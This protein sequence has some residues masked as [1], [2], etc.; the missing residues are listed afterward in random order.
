MKR[1]L[2]VIIALIIA[3]ASLSSALAVTNPATDA[4]SVIQAEDFSEASCSSVLGLGT[5]HYLENCLDVGGGQNVFDWQRNTYFKYEN[6][7]FG[8]TGAIGFQARV[9]DFSDDADLKIILDRIDGPVVGTL[10]IFST[11]KQQDWE[12]QACPITRT[13]G[14]HTVYLKFENNYAKASLNYF[15]FL[16]TQPEAQIIP[17]YEYTP[18]PTDWTGRDTKPDTWA[19][20][21]LLGNEIAG[22]YESGAP[23]ENK[24]VGIFYHLFL[25]R[26]QGAVYDNS[27]LL[28]ENYFDPAYGPV[29][30]DHF[31][32]K[33][34][35]DYY[36]NTDVYVIKKHAQLLYNAGVDVIIFDT[37]NAGFPFTP[38]WSVIVDTLYQMR[39]D[40]IQTPQIAF[41][42]GDTAEN[43]EK[44]IPYL[45]EHIYSVEK[46]KELW[47][48]WEG[49]PLILA[50]SSTL[51]TVYQNEF[52]FR[53][54]WA[55][56]SG[57]NQWPWLDN[58]PQGYGWSV[59]S[60]T[61]EATSVC[62]AQHATTFKGKS[63]SD[64]VQPSNPTEAET[65][66]M[67]NFC[68]QWERALELDPQFIFVTAWNEWVA[69]N[70]Y[71]S[72]G[73]EFLGRKLS[74][75]E[76]Y[77]IDEYSP[78]FSRDIEPTDGFLADE[79][80][81][82]LV[83]YIR[84]FKG[85]RSVEAASGTKTI[86]INNDFSQWGDVSPEYLDAVDDVTHRNELAYAGYT[87]LINTSGRNDFDSL[88]VAYDE[89]NLYFYA[90]TVA[91]IS[92]PAESNWMTLLI[93]SDN[94][95]STGWNGYDFIFNRVLVDANT[96]KLQRNV[97]NQWEWEDVNNID[98]VVS[99]NQ[100]HFAIPRSVLGLENDELKF[101][102][103]WS[104][105]AS[106]SGDV[107]D[108]Y[109]I[110]DTAPD[111]RFCYQFS[112]IQTNPVHARPNKSYT[113]TV[114]ESYEKY[115]AEYGVRS[116]GLAFES[117]HS[118]FSGIGYSAGFETIGDSL[119]LKIDSD[120]AGVYAAK[121][122]Y[123]NGQA[124]GKTLSLWVNGSKMMQLTFPVVAPSDW[125][126]WGQIIFDLPLQDGENEVVLKRENGDSGCFNIDYLGVD[127]NQGTKYEAENG[128]S[129]IAKSNMDKLYYSGTG[130]VDNWSTVGASNAVTVDAPY[131]TV[132]TLTIRYANAQVHH[133][134]LSLYV[135]SQR[136]KQVEFPVVTTSD[137]NAWGTV[138]CQIALN[139]GD[140]EIKLQYDSS[141]TGSIN[142]D[143]YTVQ[144]E[145][146][147]YLQAENSMLSGGTNTNTNHA[148]YIGTGFVDSWVSQGAT[149]SFAVQCDVTGYYDLLIRYSNGEASSKRLSLYVNGSKVETIDFP[150]V[151]AA[152]W[153]MWSEI[154]LSKIL[155][156]NKGENIITLRYDTGDSGK[157]NIDCIGI[158]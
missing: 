121:I 43:A 60:S 148:G 27:I 134:T 52:T 140:N 101:K 149:A 40:G 15:S 132:Y 144:P 126:K 105:N 20:T 42:T 66:E 155:Q 100:I 109:T 137:W 145:D 124:T 62:L 102:F 78:E 88:K 17:E 125:E 131:S 112:Q 142:I 65:L 68:E 74:A 128:V 107:M 25:T 44:L 135:N 19:A 123:A 61:P 122:R 92:T 29:E 7:D 21:D 104:D 23:R 57:Q 41:H 8:D 37:T 4:F 12:T 46:Y 38:Y 5:S 95:N 72:E 82:K 76:Y 156:L 31:W 154:S 141:D 16:T 127:F 150:V 103:K 113:G 143:S 119:T 153:E 90:K 120:A 136:I 98:F 18:L 49:K 3:V 54:S 110:G 157:I 11:G 146:A 89:T 55:W 32:G 50:N 14:I 99:G 80:Y 39:K 79:A 85:A 53:R 13:T 158:K 22:N 9:A 83:H 63:L 10:H 2:A 67:R 87:T 24:Y 77:F 71:A 108:F 81:M 94:D 33:P 116:P 34:I 106:D 111:G 93:D 91:D 73:Q 45:Y 35:F 70:Y 56:Q 130:F 138:T 1:F 30:T 151:S 133:K 6:I 58:T 152:N 36:R 115:E 64:G 96:G 139:Q 147:I 75:G 86:S 69:S 51:S 114:E 26:K 48:M 117:E 84:L 59:N 118:D 47:F 97:G 129:N 28:S